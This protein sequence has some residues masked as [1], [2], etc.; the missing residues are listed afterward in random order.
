MAMDSIFWATDG[1]GDGA[2][3]GYTMAEVIA[4]FASMLLAGGDD[5]GV[6]KG[7]WEELEVTGT[8][9]RRGD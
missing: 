2:S 3:G 8:S 1:T 4:A 9:A 7:F 6:A 5:E